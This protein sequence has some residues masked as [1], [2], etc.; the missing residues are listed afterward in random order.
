MTTNNANIHLWLYADTEVTEDGNTDAEIC[1]SLT[2]WRTPDERERL[3]KVLDVFLD[4]VEKHHEEY[5]RINAANPNDEPY[6]AGFRLVVC[7]TH[8][9]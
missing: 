6:R 3:H 5:T 1:Q 7:D 8:T 9:K 2:D 4:N